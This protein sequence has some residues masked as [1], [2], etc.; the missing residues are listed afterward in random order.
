MDSSARLLK[1]LPKRRTDLGFS[2]DGCD[3]CLLTDKEE[4]PFFGR[5]E[6]TRKLY[7]FLSENAVPWDSGLC[8]KF[9]KKVN[10]PVHLRAAGDGTTE[11]LIGPATCL[12]FLPLGTPC[13]PVVGNRFR[14]A[15]AYLFHNFVIIHT[16]ISLSDSSILFQRPTLRL[17]C[18]AGDTVESS[19]IHGQ[20][21]PVVRCLL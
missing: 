18:R 7:G 9:C 21:K 1:L 14:G 5:P 6:E 4:I 15:I 8:D 19:V 11:T 2:F 12:L 10:K 17:I 16:D 13:L 3:Q 20:A